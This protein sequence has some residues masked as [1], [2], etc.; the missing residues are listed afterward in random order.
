MK[1]ANKKNGMLTSFFV[2]AGPPQNVV[3]IFPSS[4][5]LV[6]LWQEQEKQSTRA[7]SPLSELY[8][9]WQWPR[10]VQLLVAATQ[11]LKLAWHT[12][13]LLLNAAG[14]TA[15]AWLGRGPELGEPEVSGCSAAESGAS[16]S[17]WRVKA[18]RAEMSYVPYGLADLFVFP[19]DTGM[20][21]TVL[22]CS[23]DAANDARLRRA[24]RSTLT[25]CL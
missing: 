23:P 16:D 14:I 17:A 11:E 15:W 25:A 1:P 10:P 24:S 20:R 21:T 18:D 9:F 6:V 19:V 13:T 22:S 8:F 3:L 5:T 4:S 12:E 2:H 7:A